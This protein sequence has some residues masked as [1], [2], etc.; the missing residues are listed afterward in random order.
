VGLQ[1]SLNFKVCAALTSRGGEALQ[2]QQLGSLQGFQNFA[3]FFKK[4]STHVGML[5][6]ASFRKSDAFSL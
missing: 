5:D 1:V 6:G 3:R 4:L 2:I